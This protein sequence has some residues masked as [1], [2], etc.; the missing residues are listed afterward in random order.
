M[1][2]IV[3]VVPIETDLSLITE[4]GQRGSGSL[5]WTH[6]E[7]Y[8]GGGPEGQRND[9]LDICVLLAGLDKL[10]AAAVTAALLA[11]VGVVE[12]HDG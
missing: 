7:G 11:L 9:E 12:V 3:D 4:G 10:V 6:T 1:T 8:E 2:S 5:D